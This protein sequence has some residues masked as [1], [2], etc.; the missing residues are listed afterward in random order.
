MRSIR[1]IR[2]FDCVPS[3][4]IH[5]RHYAAGAI[6]TDPGVAEVALR[7]GWGEEIAAP[8]AAPPVDGE[9]A[10]RPVRKARAAAPENK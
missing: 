7:N 3:G 8:S 9:A 5:G 1:V 10:P 6:V 2:A 4:E